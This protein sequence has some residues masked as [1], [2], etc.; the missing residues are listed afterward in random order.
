MTW[1]ELPEDSTCGNQGTKQSNPLV[2]PY[3]E[4]YTLR[5]ALCI[6]IVASHHGLEASDAEDPLVPQV[7][8]LI[9][10]N[11]GDT[12]IVE[13]RHET[14]EVES[15]VNTT[16]GD[17]DAIEGDDEYEDNDGNIREEAA[18]DPD[19]RIQQ[20]IGQDSSIV[21]RSDCLHSALNTPVQEDE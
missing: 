3:L 7:K 20:P 15:E 12:N 19:I 21:C 5:G 11:V 8:R 9:R 13:L 1:T 16:C 14:S 18:N 4:M 10:T 2:L 17:E 6:P